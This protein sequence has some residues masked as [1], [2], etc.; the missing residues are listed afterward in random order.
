MTSS[1]TAVLELC[2]RIAAHTDVAGMISRPFL[3]PATHAVHRLLLDEMGT[4]GME[5]R[6]DSIGNVRGVLPGRTPD[7]PVLLLGSHLD[8]VPNAGAYDGILGVALPLVLLR[9]IPAGTL[10]FAIELIALSEEEGVRF[11]TPFLGSR[12]LLGEL[13]AEDLARTDRA[14]TSVAQAVRDF[15]LDP[16]RL[17]DAVLTPGT[18][19]FVEVHIEQ[20]PVLESLDRQLGVVSGIVGLRFFNVTFS[21]QANH[22][23]TTPMNLRRDALTAAAEW[24]VR[25]EGFARA[26]PGL[27]ATVGMISAAPGAGNVIPGSATLSL[28]LRHVSAEALAAGVDAVLGLADEIAGE[29]GCSVQAAPTSEYPATRMSP[30]LRRLLL[31]AAP[32]AHEMPSGAGHDAMILARRVPAAMLFVRSPGGISHHPSEAVRVE[33]VAAA[34]GALHRFLHAI[35]DSLRPA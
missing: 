18:F 1:G 6:V 26:T 33:D 19:A 24:M 35:P 30:E 14:G 34:L 17:A 3:S 12:A 13:T 2:A 31:E 32:G 23:G 5:P 9:S 25:L 21:G 11:R 8:T 15:G 10:P 7:A 4:L 20:G 27:V 22:A 16:H 29:R 28:D